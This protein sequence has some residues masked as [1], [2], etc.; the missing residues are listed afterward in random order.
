M[1][2]CVQGTRMTSSAL[3]A[4]ANTCDMSVSLVPYV[5]RQTHQLIH[6]VSQ[7]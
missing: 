2:I 3:R 7:Q 1:D 5:L 6:F 4:A